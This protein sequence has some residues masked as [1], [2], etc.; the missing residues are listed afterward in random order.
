MAKCPRT[1][2][3][4]GRGQPLEQ[5]FNLLSS[6]GRPCRPSSALARATQLAEH[7]TAGPSSPQSL[8]RQPKPALR[9]PSRS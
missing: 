3:P 2:S 8:W 4:F 9:Y 6:H 7:A 1:G 5:V